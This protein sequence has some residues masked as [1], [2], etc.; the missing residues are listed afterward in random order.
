MLTSQLE[1]TMNTN[2]Y[3]AKSSLTL[4]MIE[5]PGRSSRIRRQPARISLISTV[6]FGEA[7]QQCVDVSPDISLSICL[8]YW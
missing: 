5:K 4:E 7:M 3:L 2:N 6:L 1:R 8:L